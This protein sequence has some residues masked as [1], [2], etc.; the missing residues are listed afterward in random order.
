MSPNHRKGEHMKRRRMLSLLVFVVLLFVAAAGLRW[1]AVQEQDALNR[2][3]IA[4]LAHDD[5][6]L[7]LGLVNAGADVNTPL[8]PPPAPSL[9]SL[10]RQLLHNKPRPANDSPT[11]FMLACGW[12]GT[13]K[14][15]GSEWGSVR[16]DLSL[17]KGMF[18]HG[19][20]VTA[21]RTDGETILIFAVIY[22]EADTIDLILQHGAR[23]NEP[24]SEGRTALMW[25]TSLPKQADVGVLLAH[26][27]DA[28]LRDHDGNTALYDAVA[29]AANEH[30]LRQ[31]L[32]HGADP[33]IATKDG[34][35]SI[36]IARL[37]NRP[38]TV[39]L[40]KGGSNSR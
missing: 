9:K 36:T 24:D 10:M 34:N 39:A 14:R 25:A 37:Q 28:N 15:N 4:A 26:G 27:A 32:A 1:Q 31:L 30:I 40:L 38:G 18:A 21:R 8:Y 7:A 2:N 35:T 33:S 11:A 6:K 22:S 17:V 23:V 29:S 5:T 20:D 12:P 3:L 19:A 13:V 16:N